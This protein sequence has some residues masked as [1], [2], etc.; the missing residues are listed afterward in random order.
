MENKEIVLLKK[1]LERQ[2]KARKQA[3]N[4][5]EKKSKELYDTLIQ[6]K[7]ANRILENLLDDE[8]SQMGNVFV[9]MVDP[10]IVMDLKGKMIKMNT[11]AE[12]FLGYTIEDDILLSDLVHPEYKEYSKNSFSAL[13]ATGVI[14]R[15]RPRI[16]TKEKGLKYIEINGSI[17]KDSSGKSIAAQ[18]VLRDIT[19]ESEM[20]SLLDLQRKRLNIIVENSPLGILLTVKGEL[21]KSNKT[22]QEMLGYSEDEL[23]VL[24]T[25]DFISLESLKASQELR[26]EMYAGNIHHFSLN[27]KYL[28][29][30]GTFFSAKTTVNAVHN[31]KGLLEYE[32]ALIED[33]TNELELEEEKIQ[34][35]KDLESSNKGLQEYAHIV[36]HDLK[37]PLRSI[38]ALT[39]WMYEDYK[40]KLDDNG[41][42][43][44]KMMQE[45]VESMD[46]LI[47]GIL[48]YST[49]KSDNLDNS[50]VDVNEVVKEITDII[51]I[52]DH[53]RVV[54]V[55]TLPTI[56]ADRTKI[57]QLIQNFLSNA[58]VHIEQKNGLVE[59]G[60]VER[61][62]YW[63]FSIK[64]NGVGIPKEYHEKIFKIFQSIG[65]KERSTG[66]GLSIVKK[67]IDLYEGKVWLESE[68]GK[69]TTFF[70][71]LKKQK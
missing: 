68:I 6:L 57:H 47:D 34:L 28:R 66:I 22:I 5:L 48:K 37:S 27:K 46:K 19:Y 20:K 39:T 36:S 33:I 60:C 29:K 59:V 50:S 18:G 35:V 45:K 44:L 43:N 69:G 4:I 40:D 2:K 11:A 12:E 42:F 52:P 49:I 7:E 3:E 25:Q 30:N 26:D 71:T 65:N 38:S 10:Y 13:Y 1:A 23:M 32:V 54:A 31:N 21:I 15:F 8:S 67:I 17:I 61:P 51:Y 41:V 16:F 58:V 24:Q 63:E 56:F 53:V 55:N 64:D 9:N 70:F 14:K 62:K